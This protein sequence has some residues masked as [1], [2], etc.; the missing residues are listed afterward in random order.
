V[1]LLDLDRFKAFNDEHG[2]LAGDSLLREAADAW[3]GLLRASDLLARYGGEEFGLAFPA[4]P[5]ESAR[6]V[7][8]RVRAATPGGLTCSAGLVAWNP[9]ESSRQLTDRADG[10]LYEAKSAGRD[11]TVTVS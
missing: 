4:A 6:A 10:A 8:D 11:R 7:V 2:H 5:L 1:A 9:G 3:G